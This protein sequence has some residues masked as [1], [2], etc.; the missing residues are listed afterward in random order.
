MPAK[1][2][3]DDMSRRLTATMRIGADEDAALRLLPHLHWELG[4]LMKRVGPDDLEPSELLGILGILAAAHSRL[5]TGG[6][7][8]PRR[9]SLWLVP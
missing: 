6:P 8:S 2:T 5:I 4:E 1:E 3:T 9:P 7:I